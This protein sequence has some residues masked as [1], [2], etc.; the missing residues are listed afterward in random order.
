MAYRFTGIGFPH[1]TAGIIIATFKRR[2]RVAAPDS[3]SAHA[4]V[5]APDY[6]YS[7]VRAA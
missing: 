2:A 6:I 7:G 4:V 1:E 3:R 5:V